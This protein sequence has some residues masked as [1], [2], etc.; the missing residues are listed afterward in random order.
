MLF[1]VLMLHIRVSRLMS[2]GTEKTKIY[3]RAADLV[4]MLFL[5][6]TLIVG[7]RTTMEMMIRL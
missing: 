3:P 2:F 5:A 1:M 7:L 6:L 4:T